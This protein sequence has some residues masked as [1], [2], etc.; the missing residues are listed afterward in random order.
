MLVGLAGYRQVPADSVSIIGAAPDLVAGAEALQR[1]RYEEGLALTRAGM[2][3]LLS[4]DQRAAALNN[5]CAGYTALRLHDIAIVYCTESLQITPGSWQACNN[6]AL[7]YLGKGLLMLARRDVL[8][9]LELNPGA[10]PLQQ[11][12]LLVDEA[13]RR[14]PTGPEREPPT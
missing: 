3:E 9:G 11:V 8:R 13:E 14:R 12:L 2:R 7:A 1:G 10:A 6:R 5:L 4:P